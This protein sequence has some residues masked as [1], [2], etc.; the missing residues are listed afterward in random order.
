VICR[1]SGPSVLLSAGEL[2]FDRWSDGAEYPGGAPA[3]VACHARALGEVCSLVSR[4]GQDERGACLREWLADVGV[5]AEACQTDP[6]EPTG[7][8]EVFAGGGEGPGYRIAA[9]SAWDFIEMTPAVTE[10]LRGARVLVIGTLAQRHPCARATI[11]RLVAAARGA[12][13]PVLADLN[14]RPPF[15]DEEIVRWTLRHCDVLKLNRAELQAVSAMLGASG[16]TDELFAG[17]L[18]EFGRDRGVLTCGAE[19]ALFCEEGRLWTQPAVAVAAVETTGCGDAF[20]AVLAVALARGRTL[21]EAAPLAAE[22]S[23]FVAS[24]AGATP[25]LPDDLRARAREA[26]SG[27]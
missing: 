18:R 10:A 15:F 9:R 4:V 7:T 25:R 13:V 24:Q 26:M 23:A 12:G 2:L 22:V 16:P 8:V 20:C 1:D 19:G 6:V 14:L 3:N 27:V 21:R 11:R 17:L 5:R